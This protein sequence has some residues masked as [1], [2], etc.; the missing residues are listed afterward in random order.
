M[1]PVMELLPRQ[2][3]VFTCGFRGN[4]QGS[5]CLPD[6]LSCVSRATDFSINFPT[7]AFFPL[8]VSGP[9]P[10][11]ILSFN[12]RGLRPTRRRLLPSRP[13]RFESQLVLFVFVLELL[14][15]LT[16]RLRKNRQTKM[17]I[18]T[19]IRWITMPMLV[20]S[21]PSTFN[22]SIHIE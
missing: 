20:S 18:G 6:H 15:S 21:S 13:L 22:D 4:S 8:F 14:S 7:P 3:G 11:P 2:I 1:F 17:K 19:W 10:P 5:L 9:T 16:W 12:Y